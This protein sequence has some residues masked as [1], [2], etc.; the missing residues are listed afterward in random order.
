[1]NL[2]DFLRSCENCAET[3]EKTLE[4]ILRYGA[5][6]AFGR[7]LGLDKISSPAEF[8]RRA[9]VTSWKDVEPFARSAAD[10]E[11]DQ[12]FPGFPEYCVMT[13]GTSGKSKLY[14][15]SK[16]G[17]AR[18]TEVSNLKLEAMVRLF[19]ETSAGKILPLVNPSSFGKTK[20]G[21]DFGT[22]SGLALAR[23]PEA[24]TRRLAFPVSVVDIEDQEEQDY[25]I[26]RFALLED[27]VV[28]FCNNAAR[29]AGLLRTAEKRW[30]DLLGDMESGAF[31]GAVGD[32]VEKYPELRALA[33]PAP[34]KAAELASGAPRAENFWPGLRVALC[35]LSGSVGRYVD[36]LRPLLPEKTAVMELGY[37]ATEGKFNVP[38]AS[39]SAAAPLA[40]NS[41]FFEFKP[42]DSTNSGSE[43]P[44]SAHE[45]EDGASYEMYCTTFSGLYRYAI[46]DIVRVDGFTGTT[47]NI[48]FECK[49]GEIGNI[50]G[51]KLSPVVLSEAVEAAARE[52][53]LEIVGW[54]AV[55]DLERRRYEFKMEF[56]DGAADAAD[57]FAAAVEKK[58]YGDG[59]LPYPFFRRQGFLEPATVT[60]ME[61]GWFEKWKSS[62]SAGK[63]STT[64]TQ[65]K[66]PLLVQSGSVEG[67]KRN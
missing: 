16:E 14:P 12:L 58:M 10:G 21:F 17:A 24:W 62:L 67:A 45:L 40:L 63:A 65:L 9:P 50:C 39:D 43:P 36:V 31:K 34:E 55:P 57:I 4:K 1:M 41:A 5:R 48:V 51:E 33:P 2:D 26:L 54:Y 30:D 59:T 7:K 47:P 18:K 11:P 28:A 35:W 6:S 66:I 25:A 56:A 61:K 32:V 15:E 22:A 8:K 60:R 23:A 37:G 52:T 53:G 46:K 19:P 42:R 29:L 44:L 20:G 13:S 49:S 3:Q 64:E 38:I 27:V